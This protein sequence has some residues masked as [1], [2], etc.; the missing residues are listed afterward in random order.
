[1][2]GDVIVG[3]A[4]D[5]K[6]KVKVITDK[7]DLD[8]LFSIT[9][10]Q[11]E[12]LSFI[13]E[14]FG[15]IN[16]KRRFNT[17]DILD[18]PPGI[19]GPDEDNKNKNTFRT[20]VGRWVFNKCFIEKE[21][22]PLF[23]Y[24]NKPINKKIYSWINTEISYAII[25][26]RLPLQSLKNYLMRT[27]KY[28]PYSNILAAGFTDKMLLMSK[29]L[30]PI[31]N[32]LLKQHEK[33]LNDPDK[34]LYA[35]D[36]IQKELLEYSKNY[37]KFDPSMDMYDSGAKGKFDNNFKNIFVMKGATKDPD[38]T[39]GFNIITSNLMD[40]IKKEDYAN[41]ARSMTEGPYAR[42]V[43]TQVGGYWEKL[44]LRAFQHLKLGPKGS[45][46]GTKRT[47][48]ITLEPDIMEMVM[49][50]YIVE[51]GKLIELTSQNKDKYLNKTVKMRFSSLCE[52]E[53]EGQ[54]CNA[55]AGNFFYRCGFYN[56][57]VAIPQ[58][59][60]RI[61]LIAMKAFH[62]TTVRLHEIDVAKAFGFKR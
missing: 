36:K 13:M 29:T 1:M 5:M 4:S 38:P 43:K 55:C 3:M 11:A 19:Y 12:K 33:E 45:D 56:V 8:Y 42:G 30:Q 25:E 61:K 37:L 18:V 62:D 20:T 23:K 53:K 22:F 31:K 2:K 21:L 10:K 49:Y 52:Y 26:D 40:G 44:F 32:K 57:G 58:V 15:T 48:T 24:I 50:N 46:C 51:N 27:Q 9:Q 34:K 14:T 7:R 41:M 16:N 6:R 54:I 35:I 59:A 17:Y 47:I 60:S 39:K 28:Q